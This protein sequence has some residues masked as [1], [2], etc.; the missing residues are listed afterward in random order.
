VE[1]LA[2]DMGVG[3]SLWRPGRFLAL[4]GQMRMYLLGEPIQA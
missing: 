3:M 4:A 1:A 2:A